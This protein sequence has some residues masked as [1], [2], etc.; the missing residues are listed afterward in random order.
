MEEFSAGV[1]QIYGVVLNPLLVFNKL[2]IF[3]LLGYQIFVAVELHVYVYLIGASDPVD[4]L[5]QKIG[6]AAV[7]FEILRQLPGFMNK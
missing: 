3:N 6:D 2:T 5:F 7:F 4:F 1:G